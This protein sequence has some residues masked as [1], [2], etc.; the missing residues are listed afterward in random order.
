MGISLVSFQI[1]G[2]FFLLFISFEMV[3]EKRHK[4]KETYASKIIDED[5]INDLAVF[6]I[7][8]PLEAGPSAITLSILI[9]ADFH[10]NMLDFYQQ[11][12]FQSIHKSEKTPLHRIDAILSLAHY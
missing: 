8:I 5:E 9:S 7:S 1:I 6:P 4:R 2:G 11:R 10:Y 12:E 3:L